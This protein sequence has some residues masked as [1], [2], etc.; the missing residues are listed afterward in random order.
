EEQVDGRDVLRYDFKI[1]ENR[2]GYVLSSPTGRAV[3]GQRGSYWADAKSLELLSVEARAVDIPFSLGILDLTNR[4]EY[5]RVP[6]GTSEVLL[7][8]HAQTL[9][10]NF[11]GTQKRNEMAF[12]GCREYKS[13]STIRFDT[14]K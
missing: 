6:L 4:I 8:K 10:K 5:Q 14:V 9:I 1:P 7:P 12:S 3:V 11:D 13:E 2:S